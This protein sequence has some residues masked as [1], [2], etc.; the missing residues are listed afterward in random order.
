MPPCGALATLA[1]LTTV[2]FGALESVTGGALVQRDGSG[3]TQP[4]SPPVTVATL[5]TVAVDGVGAFKVATRW[6]TAP[7]AT[8]PALVQ[9][10][11]AG[12]A[13]AAARHVPPA[14]FASLVPS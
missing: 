8:P 13:P 7:A 1:V 10:M 12:P 14:P 11:F 2:K 3:A 9:V 5:L 6:F 4:G